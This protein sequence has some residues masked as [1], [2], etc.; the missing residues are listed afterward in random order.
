MKNRPPGGVHM[1]P[2]YPALALQGKRSTR[3]KSL[4]ARRLSFIWTACAPTE[5][6]FRHPAR[7]LNTLRS[8]CVLPLV[9]VPSAELRRARALV[10]T[11][12]FPPKLFTNSLGELKT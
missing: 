12:T 7:R 6:P 4:S 11:Q 3:S 9:F 8:D 10:P 5:I 1:L 2:I